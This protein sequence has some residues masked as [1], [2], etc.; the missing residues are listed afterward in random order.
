ML[1]PI[2]LARIGLCHLEE[3]IL[4]VLFH[5]GNLRQG[6]ISKQLNIPKTGLSGGY[7]IVDGM[8]RILEGEKR[9]Q[10]DSNPNAPRWNLTEVQRNLMT[11]K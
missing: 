1:S 9:V 5:K 7:D 4:W 6:E 3:A 2:S 11:F 10:N 8:L